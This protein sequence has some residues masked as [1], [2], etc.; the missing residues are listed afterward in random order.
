M[1]RAREA[2]LQVTCGAS[3]NH[4]TLN[5]L[6]VGGYRTFLKLK[7]PLRAED[8]RLGLVEALADGL[9][10]VICSDHDPQDVDTKRLPFAE[11]EAGAIGDAKRCC[12]RA[13]ASL[14][15]DMLRCRASSAR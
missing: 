7:P 13:C 12:R 1:A 11:A 8:E 9:I 5:E 3:I 14:P 6:D 4:L 2:G 15:A 10:D